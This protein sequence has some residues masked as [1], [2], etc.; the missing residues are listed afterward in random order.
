MDRKEYAR[1]EA[2]ANVFKA[3]GH[4]SRVLVVSVLATGEKCFCELTEMIG[5][6]KSTVSKHLSVLKQAGII[7]DEK[8]GLMVFY[9]LQARC[10]LKFM[11]CVD[12]MISENIRELLAIHH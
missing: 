3:L 8:R 1:L 2:K 7:R 12:S 6:D 5:A 9:T 10:V 4:P 11:D